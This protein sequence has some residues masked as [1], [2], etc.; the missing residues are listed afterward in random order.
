MESLVFQ[1]LLVH[2]VHRVDQDSQEQRVTVVNSDFQELLEKSKTHR[3]PTFSTTYSLT[4]LLPLRVLRETLEG[5]ARQG[6]LGWQGFQ[7]PWVQ[8]DHRDLLARQ[9]HRTV[10][11]LMDMRTTMAFLDSEA[12]LDHRVH[13]AS[14]VYLES[15]VSQAHMGTREQRDREDLLGSQ[16]S[17]GSLGSR[18]KRETE[19][20]EER[21]VCQ[22]EMAAHLDLQG[23]LDPR[24]R[25][26]TTRQATGG[27]VPRVEQDFR[28]L[29]DQKETKET[30][31]LQD[32]HQK[33][34]KESLVS[35]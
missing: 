5:Q 9:G 23:H 2:Q 30:Q 6:R 1:A 11:V 16:V 31:V 21:V 14:Q 29:W 7:V 4:L 27:E 8:L 28:A 24:D 33:D 13:P 35:S 19:E 12:H 34:R 15:Q 10:L 17:M 32:M 22:G 26:P 18:A 20:R 3:T 25:S